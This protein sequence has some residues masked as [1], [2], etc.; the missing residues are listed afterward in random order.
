MSSPKSRNLD[1]F[2]RS[3]QSIGRKKLK[4]F[5]VYIIQKN[6]SLWH[7]TT[8]NVDNPE[9]FNQLINDKV[10]F[11]R[12][13]YLTHH[14]AAKLYGS[15]VDMSKLVVMPAYGINA[16]RD[17]I[18]SNDMIP[19]YHIP[20]GHGVD[21]EFNVTRDLVLFDLGNLDNIQK[22]WEKID[23]ITESD[24]K[25]YKSYIE[26]EMTLDE[27]KASLKETLINTC[28]EYRTLG[29]STS[30]KPLK[31]KRCIRKS[32]DWSDK[33]LEAFL[34]TYFSDCVGES[35]DGWVYFAD[36]MFG[37]NASNSRGNFHSEVLLCNPTATIKFKS[38]HTV[39]DTTYP[40]IPTFEQFKINKQPYTKEL[41][42]KPQKVYVE[43][44][45]VTNYKLKFPQDGGRRK[46]KRKSGTAS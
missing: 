7:G 34:C 31:P 6:K 46:N 8:A 32:I 14:N 1:K 33:D 39:P 29:K 40:G 27:F 2:R 45:H 13:F 38:V 3:D 44:F 16:N 42:Q 24:A 25:K 4:G 36:E 20:N 10:A 37:K 18:N 11:D 28:A 17:V 5:K 26:Y 12:P 43:G 21:I 35:V 30:Y 23:T 9:W 41:Y 15:E 19:I 22:L